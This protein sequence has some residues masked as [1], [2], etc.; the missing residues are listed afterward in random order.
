MENLEKELVWCNAFGEVT[1]ISKIG[2]QHLS[3]ILWYNEVL[4]GMNRYNDSS[5]FQLVLEL[6]K[7]FPSSKEPGN[8]WRLEWKPLPIPGELKEL[9]IQGLITASGRIL[10]NKNTPLFEGKIIGCLNH[11]PNWE[12]LIK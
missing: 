5:H 8:G 4:F 6:A 3:N 11:I 12:E 1:P 2:H 9:Q 7:R 10:G